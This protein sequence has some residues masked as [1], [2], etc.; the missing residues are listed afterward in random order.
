MVSLRST[1]AAAVIEDR[2]VD[3]MRPMRVVCIGA[4][5]SGIITAIRFSQKLPN[6]E[7]RIYE[8]NMD[9]GGTWYENKYPGCACGLSPC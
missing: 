9:I 2:S 1:P 4:G 7:L 5:I 8:K 3:D 6:V